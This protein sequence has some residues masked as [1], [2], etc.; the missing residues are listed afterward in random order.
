VAAPDAWVKPIDADS[1]PAPTSAQADGGLDYLLIDNQQ[2]MDPAASFTHYTMRLTN[3][4]G[5][6]KGSDIR[7]EFAPEYQTLTLHWLRVKRDG[8]WQDRLTPDSFQ[9]IR[10]EENLDSQ[11]LDGRYSA[12]C[13]LQDVR[14]GDQVDFAFTVKGENPVFGGKYLESFLT[15]YLRPVHL[16]SNQLI[17][18]PGRTVYLKNFGPSMEPTRTQ[19][20]DQSES[21]VWKQQDMPAAQ[22]EPQTPEWYDTFGWTQVTEYNSWKDVVDWGLATFSLS[23]TPSPELADKITEIRMGHHDAE[24]RALAV[25]NF[26]QNDIRYL[27]VEMGANSYKPTPASQVFEHRFGDCKDKTQ[28]CVVMLN[29]LGIE[30]YPALVNSARG[31]EMEN[32]LPS[33]LAFDHAIVQLTV[34]ANTYWIDMTRSNQCGPLADRYV[35]DFKKVLLLRPGT[36]GLVPMKSSAA[37]LPHVEIDKTYEVKSV[38]DPVNFHI[39]SI[40]EGHAAEAE[41]DTVLQESQQDLENEYL[42]YYARAYPDIKVTKPLH[43]QNFPDSNR[44][45]VWQD[46]SIPHLWT[47]DTPTTPWKA[48]FSPYTVSSAI[49]STTSTSRKSPFKLLHPAD[50]TEHIEIDMFRK[51]YINSLPIQVQ[52]SYF[53]FSAIPSVNDNIVHFDYHFK[54]LAAAVPASD[55]DSYNTDIGKVRQGLDCGLTYLPGESGAGYKPNLMAMTI[56]GLIFLV[57]VACAFVIYRLHPPEDLD[58]PHGHHD[59]EGVGGWLVLHVIALVVGLGMHCFTLFTDFPL[60][61]DLTKWNILTQPGGARYDA[62]V[63]PALLFESTAAIIM[64]VLWA[65]ALILMFQKKFTLPYVM[66]A[67]LV[68]GSVSQIVDHWLASQVVT[69]TSSPDVLP[70][71]VIQCMVACGIWIPYF[72]V[73]KRVK[74]T[75]VN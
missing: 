44:I 16:F 56:A 64:I 25:I 35:N 19:N 14:V 38:T 24:E 40:Y 75:F 48:D 49:G 57:A 73:S 39:H 17:T 32:M 36:T 30:A 63:A 8:A 31:P 43:F 41:R 53:D 20:P 21:I 4:E 5:L 50:I 59:L 68:T 72:L 6:E 1:V 45:E 46:Y 3:E 11:M 69:L 12:I 62:A 74:V 28:L 23:D 13:H 42:N 52:N 2:Q 65:L 47:R 29:A 67:V 22:L 66:I 58:I 51:W 54:T 26:V 34:G 9:V 71:L 33:P 55:I 7:A 61:F 10:R 27:G 60:M 18:A 15:S 37:S 70:R